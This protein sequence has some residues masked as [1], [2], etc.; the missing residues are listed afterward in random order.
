M[1]KESTAKSEVF[2]AILACGPTGAIGD[3]LCQQL[4][5][6]ASTVTG[7]ISDLAREG[8]LEETTGRETKSGKKAKAWR[9]IGPMHDVASLLKEHAKE[10]HPESSISRAMTPQEFA[11]LIEGIREHG[12]I[13]SV[14]YFNGKIVDG[15]HRYLA[16]VTLGIDHD[17][18]ELSEREVASYGGLASYV[19]ETSNRKHDNETQRAM[20][21][22]RAL[23]F[24]EKDAK[25]RQRQA[26]GDKKSKDAKSVSVNL[27]EPISPDD[28]KGKAAD[29]AA[30]QAN[31]SGKS[32]SDAKKV[33]QKAIPEIVAACDAGT[34]A[35]SRAA[36]IAD[37]PEGRQRKAFKEWKD[38]KSDKK[39]SQRIDS[40]PS[41]DDD[42]DEEIET[43]NADTL[44]S[45]RQIKSVDEA[46]DSL[47]EQ[48]E[49]LWLA[50]REKYGG[51]FSSCKS[52]MFD[53]AK[54][55]K[56]WKRLLQKEIKNAIS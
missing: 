47:Y 13:E 21:A 14:V 3:E 56:T 7:R 48:W 23:P 26:G 39:Q 10:F 24:F 17:Y 2:A 35:V 20:A 19:V 50:D 12:Q 55:W 53:V 44:E 22:A 16:C 33:Q 27:P 9:A 29:L 32:V 40:S 34:L 25:E 43:D 6:P 51:H 41:F 54:T 5:Y 18:R 15:R 8:W 30:K 1:A 37:E 38:G 45:I 42:D 52:Q 46:I 11:S 28:Q 31:V 36:K 4:N 49:S